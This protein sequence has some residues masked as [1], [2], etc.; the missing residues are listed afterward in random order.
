MSSEE[1]S[2]KVVYIVMVAFPVIFGL[3]FILQNMS[4]CS[5]A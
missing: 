2:V 3:F 5:D 4:L 1:D